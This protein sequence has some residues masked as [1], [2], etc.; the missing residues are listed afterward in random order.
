MK[1]VLFYNYSM[2]EKESNKM[3][4]FGQCPHWELELWINY[5]MKKNYI[6]IVNKTLKTLEGFHGYSN[7]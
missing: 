4:E 3:K 7:L 5:A 1:E 2:L 6:F